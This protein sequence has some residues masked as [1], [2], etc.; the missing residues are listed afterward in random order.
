[1]TELPEEFDIELEALSHLYGSD[2]FTVSSEETSTTLSIFLLPRQ[3]DGEHE[4]YVAAKLVLTIDNTSYPTTA[5]T[6]TLEEA[7]GL[8]D[9][10]CTELEATLQAEA[11]N[12]V[13][14][15]VLGHLCELALDLLTENNHPN[16]TCVFCLEDLI[17]QTQLLPNSAGNS[18]CYH[19]LKLPC[20]HCFHIP[21]FTAWFQWH[22][23]AVA[24]AAAELGAPG[25]E[26]STPAGH[27]VQCENGWVAKSVYTIKCPS[28]RLEI[29][30]TALRYALP[31]LLGAVEKQ[32]QEE[33]RTRTPLP[34]TPPKMAATKEFT[35][36][37]SSVATWSAE[38]P[39]AKDVLSPES[40]HQLVEMQRAFKHGLK[41]QKARN[42][43]VQENVA[44]SV[45]ELEAAAAERRHIQQQKHDE[46][47]KKEF[48]EEASVSIPMNG[49][50]DGDGCRNESGDRK[51]GASG[52]DAGRGTRGRRRGRGR[53]SHPRP[54]PPP[55]P[56]SSY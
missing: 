1:M 50:L 32:Q 28:C 12:L 39:S 19:I 30:P 33:E 38:H 24:A 43:L 18:S 26:K 11:D 44:V 15:M 40:L 37:S 31:Q 54:P 25:Q 53:A 9:A 52:R 13:G 49:S 4:A 27:D 3:L 21:C 56:A 47:L 7:K 35:S 51:K 5:A 8:T 22:Q 42:G 46:A 45:A 41:L 10:V 17:C 2:A 34:A 48:K 14:E 55:A 23:A 20:F 16:G 29:P 36:R 6:A